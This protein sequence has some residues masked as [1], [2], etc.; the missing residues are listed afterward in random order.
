MVIHKS[1]PYEV[2]RPSSRNRKKHEI[3]VISLLPCCNTKK[4]L[5]RMNRALYGQGRRLPVVLTK[6]EV[7]RILDRMSGMKKSAM[8]PGSP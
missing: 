1:L 6:G 3:L 5:S 2:R 8:I 7:R 4:R